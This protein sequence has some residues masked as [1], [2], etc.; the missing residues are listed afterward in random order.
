MDPSLI[1]AVALGAVVVAVGASVVV[2]RSS[3]LTA[4]KRASEDRRERA[5]RRTEREW[6][7]AVARHREKEGTG[8]IEKALAARMD[9]GA[10]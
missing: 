9:D 5:A 7:K 6:Q 1:T 10:G 4:Q 2:W 3:R 8:V